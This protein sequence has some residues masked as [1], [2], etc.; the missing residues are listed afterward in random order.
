MIEGIIIKGI[1]GFYYVRTKEKVYECRARGLFREENIKPLVG[2]R[3]KIRL[4][5]DGTGYVEE[6]LERKTKLLRPAVANVDQAIIVMSLRSPDI[7]LWLLDRFLLMAEY[8]GLDIIIALSK[9]DLSD[10]ASIEKI[11]S[12]YER[13]GYRLVRL[14]SLNNS[15]I[16]EIKDLLKDKITVFAGPS[17]VGKSTLLN[18]IDGDLKLETGL[19]S[20]KT[21]RGKHTTRHVELMSLKDNSYVLDTPGF[22][23]LDLDFIESAEELSQYFREFID[24]DRPC[25]FTGCLH[26]KEPK[27]SVKERVSEGLIAEERYKNYLK[28]LEEVNNIRR[29]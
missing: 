23:S 29:Y 16:E 14:S 2:D 17:G 24:E 6:I 15:G 22:S 20:E 10:E 26:N 13:A 11:S 12:I 1:G 4:N 5:D 8:E 18:T 3:V 21:S 27:C 9:T 7:N 25:K 19:V 28:I